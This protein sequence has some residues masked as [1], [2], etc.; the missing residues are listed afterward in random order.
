[1]WSAHVYDA[2]LCVQHNVNIVQ[3]FARA[4]QM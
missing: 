1:M 2:P 3:V 4:V